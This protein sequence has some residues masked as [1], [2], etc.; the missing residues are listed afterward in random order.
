MA[1]PISRTAAATGSSTPSTRY[2][3]V[4]RIGERVRE[5]L[6]AGADHVCLRVVT[7]A[8]MTGVE[9]IP[10][11]EWRELAPLASAQVSRLSSR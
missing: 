2:G 10:R 11:E 6:A 4:E 1:T 9:R 5:H 8:P 7:N 3:S